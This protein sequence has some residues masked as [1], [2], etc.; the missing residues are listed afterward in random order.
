MGDPG[1]YCDSW[2]L[3]RR[4]ALIGR[5]RFRPMKP[6]F[7]IHRNLALEWEDGR[8]G[9]IEPGDFC[10]CI[11]GRAVVACARLRQWA[12]AARLVFARY[13]VRLNHARDL[14]AA[15]PCA[16]CGRSHGLLP[17]CGDLDQRDPASLAGYRAAD[18]DWR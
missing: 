5:A 7:G 8:G 12:A 6:D 9:G 3:V 2:R 14:R 17:V 11:D 15:R 18:M 13:S 1:S 16:V 10:A 4:R